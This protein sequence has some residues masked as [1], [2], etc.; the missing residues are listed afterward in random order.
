M[1]EMMIVNVEYN[2]LKVEC[3]GDKKTFYF[4]FY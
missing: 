1:Y 2:K 4:E 3:H